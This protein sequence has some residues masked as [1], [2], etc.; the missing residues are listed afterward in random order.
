MKPMVMWQ[1]QAT[2]P[3]PL[4][5]VNEVIYMALTGEKNALLSDAERGSKKNFVWV[6]KDFFQA[7]PEGNRPEDVSEDAMG[8]LSL[9][10]SYAKNAERRA[11][12][13][14]SPKSSISIMPRTD[15]ASLYQDVSG[16]LK[17]DLYQLVSLL[18]CYKNDEGKEVT[19][20]KDLTNQ[21]YRRQLNANEHSHRFDKD[22]CDGDAKNPKPKEGMNKK[23]L[24]TF[25][26]ADP[27][28]QK[29]DTKKVDLKGWMEMLPKGKDLLAEADG[30]IDK[31]IGGLGSAREELIGNPKRLI[32]L[33]EFRDMGSVTSKDFEKTVNNIED[34][35]VAL[36]KKYK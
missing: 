23:T 3:L 18:A 17:G 24:M 35:L 7:I 30:L 20:V 32:P 13:S 26:G 22:F 4:A 12:T 29:K 31:Q 34:A 1:Y 36:H 16:S 2:A 19:Y 25:E 28:T 11:D 33:F 21:T 9:V 27:K 14:A 5:A 15:F 10:L 8:F 6:N